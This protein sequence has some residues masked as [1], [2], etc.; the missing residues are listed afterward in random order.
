[1]TKEVRQGLG[2]LCVALIAFLIGIATADGTA[3][4]FSGA[5]RLIGLVLAVFGLGVIASGLF[6]RSA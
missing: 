4:W 1:M 5:L 3:E 2:L 6:R